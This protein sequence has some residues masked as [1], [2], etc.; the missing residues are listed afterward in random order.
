M[1]NGIK[2]F[3]DF[4]KTFLKIF[5]SLAANNFC[6]CLSSSLSFSCV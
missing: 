5:I 1:T 4:I 3:E 2:F 6:I